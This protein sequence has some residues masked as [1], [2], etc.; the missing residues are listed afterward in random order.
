MWLQM[1][2]YQLLHLQ[3]TLILILFPALEFRVPKA[4]R[5]FRLP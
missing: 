4:Y 2:L 3:M 1:L 5:A